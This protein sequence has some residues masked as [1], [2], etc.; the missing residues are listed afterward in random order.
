[1]TSSAVHKMPKQLE[2]KQ[3]TLGVTL[4]AEQKLS[5]FCF[6]GAPALAQAVEHMLIQNHADSVYVFGA[7]GVG[8]SHFLQGCVLKAQDL[9]KDALYISGQELANIPAH[10]ASECL[11]GLEFNHLICVDDIDCLI[12]D[13]QWAQAWFHLYNQLMQLGRQL[14]VAAKTNPRTIDCPL[15]D[16]RSRLQLANVFQLNTLDEKATREVLKAKAKQKGLDLSDEQVAYIFSRSA[17]SLP[18]LLGVLDLLDAA[19]WHEKRR[20]TIPFIKQVMAW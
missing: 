18:S 7:Q 3:L 8:K 9:G 14:V 6:D 15:D 12:A 20:I 13:S 10:Q 5:N 11:T 1:M 17:R 4:N 2:L 19:S 16:L